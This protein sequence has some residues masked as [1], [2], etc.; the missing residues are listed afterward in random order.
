MSDNARAQQEPRGA[1][2][3]AAQLGAAAAGDAAR[4]AGGALRRG[5]AA[6]G[7]AAERGA[8]AAGTLLRQ[9]G[10]ALGGAEAAAGV[11]LER[12]ARAAAEGQHRLAEAVQ[13][14]AQQLHRLMVFPQGAEGGMR[15][16]QQGLSELV[17]GVA[18]TNLRAI[19]E[20]LRLA[21]PSGAIALQQ[22]F[23]RDYLDALVEG[24][25]SILRAARRTAEETL[26]PL[27]RQL[28][29]QRQQ[30]QRQAGTRRVGEVMSRGVRV[31]SPDD[32][33]QQAAR[34]MREED[35]GVL[36]VGEQDRLVGMVTDCDVAV[37]LV[38]EGRDPAKTKVREVMT[39]E[40]RYVFEDEDLGHVA[41]NM[42]E[43]QVR[44]LPVV[45]RDRRLVGIVSLGDLATAGRSPRL[46]GR[47]LGGVAR[48]GGPHSQAAAE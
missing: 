29:E 32:T 27:E 18:R 48:E 12:S 40:V 31:A 39:P 30:R 10:E 26:Q 28:E 15:D 22:R 1:A 16:L 7:E 19:E 6:S 34:L 37:R 4:A 21:D 33:V 42:A 14:G 17:E 38:A 41:E 36:P 2:A 13:Q 8:D 3:E 5:A 44:R 46:A 47:A 20:L 9:D 25:A 11:V 43:Q 24:G 23:V 45:N 35:S